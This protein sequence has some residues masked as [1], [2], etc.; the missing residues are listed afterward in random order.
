MSGLLDQE[1]VHQCRI[2]LSLLVMMGYHSQDSVAYRRAATALSLQTLEHQ[3]T[4]ARTSAETGAN[5]FFGSARQQFQ[6][7]N[8][9]MPFRWHQGGNSTLVLMLLLLGRLARMQA[10]KNPTQ[11]IGAP[12]QAMGEDL[13]VSARL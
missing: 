6:V 8:S 11:L 9:L 7:V 12:I 1:I 5:A 2:G 4:F 10:V 3:R 13:R